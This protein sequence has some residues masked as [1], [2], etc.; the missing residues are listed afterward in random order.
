MRI[1]GTMQRGQDEGINS[2]HKL[3]IECVGVLVKKMKPFY[4]P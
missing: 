3:V 2:A 1:N 4:L